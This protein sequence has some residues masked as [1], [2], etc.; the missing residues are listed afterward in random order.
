MI[1]LEEAKRAWETKKPVEY[2]HP[3]AVKPVICTIGAFEVNKRLNR[4]SHLM[5]IQPPGNSYIRTR[6]AFVS[7]RPSHSEEL[8]KALA[9]LDQLRKEGVEFD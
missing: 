5:L 2:H 6:P 8:T 7:L 1:T 4:L 3:M 9:D